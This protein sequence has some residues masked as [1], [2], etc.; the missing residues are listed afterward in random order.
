[1]TETGYG[2]PEQEAKINTMESNEEKQKYSICFVKKHS[3]LNY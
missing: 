2:L 3:H 1:M